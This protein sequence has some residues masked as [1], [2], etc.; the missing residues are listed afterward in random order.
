MTVHYHYKDRPVTI[1]AGKQGFTRGF[2]FRVVT[3][4]ERCGFRT[5]SYTLYAGVYLCDTCYQ[6]YRNIIDN[7][8]AHAWARSMM[9]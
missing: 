3:Q 4:C 7:A 8:V 1:K 9:K 2:G 5:N 6:E